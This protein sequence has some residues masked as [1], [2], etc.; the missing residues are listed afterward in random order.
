MG[1]VAGAVSS[2]TSTPSQQVSEW[3]ANQIAPRYWVPN[4]EILVSF[5]YE[6]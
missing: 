2:V 4:S 6:L 5:N 1:T 3:F